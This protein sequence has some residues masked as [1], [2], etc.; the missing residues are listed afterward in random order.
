MMPKQQPFGKD[1]PFRIPAVSLDTYIRLIQ[2]H[3]QNNG[4]MCVVMPLAYI[5]HLKAYYRNMRFE[6]R[7]D[8]SNG[9]M[10]CKLI[11]VEAPK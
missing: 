2:W 9:Y 11:A 1:N 4:S 7:G 5:P 6:Q 3:I 10:R 8:A